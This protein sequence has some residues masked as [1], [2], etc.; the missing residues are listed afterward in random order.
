MLIRN[1]SA[2]P[3][4]FAVPPGFRLVALRRF[5][6]F[7]SSRQ[8]KRC[9]LLFCAAP[10]PRRCSFRETNMSIVFG[11]V[12]ISSGTSVSAVGLSR[13]VSTLKPIYCLYSISVCCFRCWPSF[14][15]LCLEH[16]YFWSFLSSSCYSA[17]Q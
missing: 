1:F 17:K 3:Q 13:L 11:F 5:L 12:N 10:F 16:G 14:F 4:L 8:G 15:R 9:C 2:L 7:T 6:V